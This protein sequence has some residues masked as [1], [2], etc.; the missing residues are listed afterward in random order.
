MEPHTPINPNKIPDLYVP[1]LKISKLH[2]AQIIEKHVI[3][4]DPVPFIN[5]NEK[6]H[7]EIRAKIPNND[8]LRETKNLKNE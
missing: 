6:D 4:T 2:Q 8:N 5:I 3:K 7:E 1:L